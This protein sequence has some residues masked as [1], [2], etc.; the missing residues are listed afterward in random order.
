MWHKKKKKKNEVE[1]KKKI[2]K[3]Y[4]TRITR[5][6]DRILYIYNRCITHICI[7]EMRNKKKGLI[8]IIYMNIIYIYIFVCTHAYIRKRLYVLRKKNKK[9]ERGVERARLYYRYLHEREQEGRA[10][11]QER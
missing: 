7:I 9:R 8:Y 11:R 3:L 6:C 2:S 1:W 5:V 4:Y 10:K